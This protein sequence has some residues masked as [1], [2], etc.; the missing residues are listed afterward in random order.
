MGRDLNYKVAQAARL[1]PWY[2][3]RRMRTQIRSVLVAGHLRGP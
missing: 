3:L 2:R 1:A